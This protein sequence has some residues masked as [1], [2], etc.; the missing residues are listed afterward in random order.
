MT[1]PLISGESRISEGRALYLVFKLIER[2]SHTWQSF[3][4]YETIALTE[5]T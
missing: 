5:V 1:S 3:D 4:G 2:V